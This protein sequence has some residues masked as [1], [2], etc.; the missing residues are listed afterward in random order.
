[1]SRPERL[2]H[3]LAPTPGRPSTSRLRWKLRS[4]GAGNVSRSPD[5]PQ[6]DAGGNKIEPA[7]TLEARR[8][9]PRSGHRSQSPGSPKHGDRPNRTCR[10]L[11]RSERPG[12]RSRA[13]VL[14]PVNRLAHASRSAG[15]AAR[16]RGRLD[17]RPAANPRATRSR[18]LGPLR[19]RERCARV[20]TPRGMTALLPTTV[21]PVLSR[22]GSRRLTVS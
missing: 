12:S 17:G 18:P 19:R 6:R 16:S 8:T 10:R 22:P 14:F 5:L 7:R 9:G 20:L 21:M 3:G 15:F 11:P 1:M 2:E 13:H 4:S